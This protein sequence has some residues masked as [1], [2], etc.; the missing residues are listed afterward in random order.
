V[1]C[2]KV[3]YPN[4]DAAW[5]AR[6]ARHISTAPMG[7]E[8]SM[9][10]HCINFYDEQSHPVGDL[11]ISNASRSDRFHMNLTDILDEDDMLDLNEGQVRDLKEACEHF[12]A[13][14]ANA[15]TEDRETAREAYQAHAGHYEPITREHDA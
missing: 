1:I 7:K 4:E 14:R 11:W 6:L 12:L 9:R 8:G 15:R 2:S 13:E 3:R 5:T 10:A